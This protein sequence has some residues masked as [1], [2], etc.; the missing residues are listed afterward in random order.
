M[1]LYFH[2][3]VTRMCAF[4]SSYCHTW[5][6]DRSYCSS[7][8]N[9]RIL[10]F[11]GN[12]I[13]EHV[14]CAVPFVHLVSRTCNEYALVIYL[15]TCLGSSSFTWTSAFCVIHLMAV[16]PLCVCACVCESSCFS[17]SAFNVYVCLLKLQVLSYVLFMQ[18]VMC[19][20]YFIYVIPLP[21]DGTLL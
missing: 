5:V 13:A 6:C 17:L 8:S 9:A 1:H 4:L 18:P 7:S 20:I 15:I 12:P 10:H 3:G 14:I 21:T 19:I 2:R 16:Y 11:H